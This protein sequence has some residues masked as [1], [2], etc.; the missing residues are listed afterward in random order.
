MSASDAALPLDRS[1]FTVPAGIAYLDNA[2]VGPLPRPAVDAVSDAAVEAAGRG[3]TAADDQAAEAEGL[4]RDLASLVGAPPDRIA[5]VASTSMALGQVAAGLPWRA[6]DAAV[7]IEGDHP[8]TV[9]PWRLLGG[10]VEVLEVP[11]GPL[12]QLSLDD[13]DAALSR[14]DGRVRV[15][16]L[17]WVQAHS[18][19]RADLEATAEVVHAHGALLCVDGIQGL[20]ARPCSFDEWTIDVLAAGAQK[21]SF[22]PQGIGLL[23]LSPAA[24][25]RVAPIAGGHGVVQPAGPR[26][27]LV[28]APTARR[29]EGGGSSAALVAGW[30]ASLA[31]LDQAGVATVAEWTDRLADRLCAGAAELGLEVRSDRDVAH[32]SAIVRLGVPGHDDDTVVAALAARRVVVSARPGG[33]RF[34]PAGWNSEADIDA[35]LVELADLAAGATSS[36]SGGA[37]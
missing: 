25:D 1:L 30:R 8:S 32:R 27:G 18:G 17:S 28:A 19:W 26:D 11:T 5:L 35:A 22:G 21:W 9:L 14:A 2:F 20:G 7:V 37:G 16:A 29:H 15:V 34:S 4:R 36:G 24:L 23:A 3:S 33:V 31:L 13:L 12:G 6:G 10:D